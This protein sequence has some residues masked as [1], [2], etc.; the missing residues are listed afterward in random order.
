MKMI[1]KLKEKE[2]P[3]SEP[4]SEKKARKKPASATN[5]STNFVDCFEFTHSKRKKNLNI[6]KCSSANTLNFLSKILTKNFCS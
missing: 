3:Q 4:Q 5:S 2:K 1:E 6:K